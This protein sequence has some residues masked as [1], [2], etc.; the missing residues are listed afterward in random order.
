MMKFRNLISLA[1]IVGLFAS[2]TACTNS[3]DGKE[4]VSILYPN[5]VEAVAYSYLS[6]VVLEEKGY[7]W[8]KAMH[9]K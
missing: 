2:F 7:D 4:K 9:N 3:D 6:K 8:I 1:L 5:W